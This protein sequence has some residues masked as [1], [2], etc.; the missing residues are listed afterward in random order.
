MN[1]DLHLN[2]NQSPTFKRKVARRAYFTS[3]AGSFAFILALAGP[4]LRLNLWKVVVL[5]YTINPVAEYSGYFSV[6]YLP[7]SKP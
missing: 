1:S 2:I 5:G 4:R 3:V 6:Y 7:L